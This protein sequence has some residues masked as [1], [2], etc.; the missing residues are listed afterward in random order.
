VERD[1]RGRNTH[2]FRNDAG[3]KAIVASNQGSE[4]GLFK[5]LR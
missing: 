2:A 3:G 1:I 4:Q 5:I